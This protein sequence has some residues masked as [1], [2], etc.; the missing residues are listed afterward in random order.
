M[1]ASPSCRHVARH[2]NAETPL[3]SH[4]QPWGGSVPCRCPTTRKCAPSYCSLKIPWR[5][6]SRSGADWERSA[7]RVRH[8]VVSLLD[9]GYIGKVEWN[10][11]VR[12]V[13]PAVKVSRPTLPG[14]CPQSA[15]L[16]GCADF[17]PRERVRPECPRGPWRRTDARRP[18]GE[19]P[20]RGHRRSLPWE[21]D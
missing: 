15:S 8:P 1:C 10:L 14:S 17:W 13:S 12:G 2:S 20:V 16:R 21:S 3:A 11:S 19:I 7:C 6:P 9:P 4:R 18:R 5:R